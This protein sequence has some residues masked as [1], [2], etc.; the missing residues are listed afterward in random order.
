MTLI[1]Y[2][3][4]YFDNRRRFGP[5]NR[6]LRSQVKITTTTLALLNRDGLG[7]SGKLHLPTAR[8]RTH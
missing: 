3:A 2:S 7:Q 6:K 5:E 1:S 8:S 4:A